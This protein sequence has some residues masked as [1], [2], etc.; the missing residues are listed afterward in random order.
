MRSAALTVCALAAVAAVGM[1]LPA[2]AVAQQAGLPDVSI[3]V[4]GSELAGGGTVASSLKIMLLLTVLSFAPAMVLCMTCFTRIAVV[5]GMTRSEE[6][7]SEL[8]SH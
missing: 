6:H 1:W 4:G 5:L 7:T 2:Q 3:S 8:Q